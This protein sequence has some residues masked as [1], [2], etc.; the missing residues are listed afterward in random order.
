[1]A[2]EAFEL[3]KKAGAKVASEQ[4]I[5]RASEPLVKELIESA[6]PQIMLYARDD[7]KS[8][9]HLGQGTVYFGTGGT[10]LNI[11]DYPSGECR[12]ANLQ[13][14]IDDV[15]RITDQLENVHLMLLPTY[16]NEIDTNDVDVNRFLTG[17]NC[18]AK[19]IMGGV[20]TAQGIR[21]VIAMAEDVAGSPEALRERPFIS[22]I[23]RGISPLRLDSKYG[24]FMIQVARESIPL[25][26]PVEP[27]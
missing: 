1:M 10:A 9:I 2:P 16:P 22:M 15:V 26:V 24:A 4:R 18:T 13:D 17:L 20:Y 21:D 5:V 12:P 23:T 11:L 19:H 7:G 25:A 8:D 14:L 3:F 27:L 6:P